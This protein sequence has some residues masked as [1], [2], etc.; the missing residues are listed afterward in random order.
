MDS[1]GFNYG[2]GATGG[3]RDI[4][5]YWHKRT[6]LSLRIMLFRRTGSRT[7]W[8][9]IPELLDPS[10]R[11]ECQDTHRCHLQDYLG[12]RRSPPKIPVR[13]YLNRGG[14]TFLLRC[15]CTYP[16]CTQER[17]IPYTL[18]WLQSSE[19]SRNTK[20]VPRTTHRWT[21]WQDKE[22]KVVYKVR[23]EE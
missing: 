15:C 9:Q 10:P 17:R 11:L 8:T 12:R 22:R 18:R 21:T 5:D 13:E 3:W 7:T 6:I 1:W 19:T 14:P 4:V 23:P 20:Q 16:I 2:R